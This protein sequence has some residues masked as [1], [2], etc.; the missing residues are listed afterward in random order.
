MFVSN[1]ISGR[2]RILCTFTGTR[3]QKLLGE[4]FPHKF[5][6]DSE[7]FFPAKELAKKCVEDDGPKNV[8][9]PTSSSSSSWCSISQSFSL[10]PRLWFVVLENVFL[11]FF[12]D[13]FL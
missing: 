1:I 9:Q 12:L 4:H 13:G 7:H 3:S 11:D 2:R 10:C 5:G 8:I 6:K